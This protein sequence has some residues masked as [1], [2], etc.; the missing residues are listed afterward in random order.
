MDTIVKL[1]GY[2]TGFGCMACLGYSICALFL[3]SRYSSYEERSVKAL[4]S[5]LSQ[6]NAYIDPRWL[7]HLS[8]V[9]T[10]FCFLLG[11]AFGAGDIGFGLL[12]GICFAVAGAIAPR[13][14]IG[15]MIAKRLDKLNR[16]LPMG[17]DMLS[18]SLR[19]GLTLRQA[20]ERNLKNLPSVMAE[21]MSVV[22]HET[23][24]GSGLT[25]A[26]KHWADRVGLLDA[27]IIVISAEISLRRGGSL[28]DTFDTMAEL[29][30]AKYVFKK[31]I[32]TLTSEGRM[33]ALVMT[34]LPFVILIIMTLVQREMMLEF[35]MS[36][37]GVVLLLVVLIMQVG[38]YFWIRKIVSIEA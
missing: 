26:L 3:V 4:G 30:R 6:I 17:L 22:I 27:R 33:Q 12:F 11:F 34:L 16:Q 21:E 35:M 28:T 14:V 13:I 36:R 8:V 24:L 5:Q 9:M 15:Y 23:R 25:E 19:A 7:F 2:A 18:S 20:I 38:A 1:F 37:L 29:I 10:V 32:T 31:E